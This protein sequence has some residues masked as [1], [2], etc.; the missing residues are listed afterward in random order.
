MLLNDGNDTHFTKSTGNIS[1]ID[2]TLSSTSIGS[3]S[4]WKVITAIFSSDYWPIIINTKYRNNS[5][6]HELPPKW[7]LKNPNWELYTQLTDYEIGK[8]NIPENEDVELTL[9]TLKNII[10]TSATKSIGIT[11]Y[12]G[13]KTPVPWWNESYNTSI[14]NKKRL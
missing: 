9:E 12:K 6:C 4:E 1:T 10:L 2:L 13:K 5:E 3:N 7:K 11:C 14:R 8:M